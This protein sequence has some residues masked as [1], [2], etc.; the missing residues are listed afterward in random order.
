MI[1]QELPQ[2]TTSVQMYQS[3]KFEYIHVYLFIS[4]RVHSNLKNRIHVSR[5]PSV[6][7]KVCQVIIL[8][9]QIGRIQ[10]HLFRKPLDEHD[11]WL[12]ASPTD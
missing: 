1:L 12:T 2:H 8:E 11:Y 4:S 7:W 10:D 6:T 5:W 3:V 9:S